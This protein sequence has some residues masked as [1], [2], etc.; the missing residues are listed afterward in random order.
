MIFVSRIYWNVHIIQ[1]SDSVIDSFNCVLQMSRTC[2]IQRIN[3]SWYYSQKAHDSGGETD[4]DTEG[5]SNQE[6]AGGGEVSRAVRRRSRREKIVSSKKLVSKGQQRRCTERQESITCQNIDW[7][8]RHNIFMGN[9]TIQ[10]KWGLVCEELA[11]DFRSLSRLQE[12]W[13]PSVSFYPWKK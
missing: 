8:Q 2:A 7:E 3:K 11:S 12:N 4:H 9:Q 10:P 1:P 5:S 13:V 6:R